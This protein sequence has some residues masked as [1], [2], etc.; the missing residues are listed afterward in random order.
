[1]TRTALDHDHDHEHD[2]DDELTLAVAAAERRAALTGPGVDLAAVRRRGRRR[3]TARRVA[4]V[5]PVLAVVAVAGLAWQG[6]GGG[7]ASLA[8]AGDGAVRVTPEPISEPTRKPAQKPTQPPV[9]PERQRA[10]L[11]AFNAALAAA[12]PG[13]VPLTTVDGSWWH[14]EQRYT[15]WSRWEVDGRS[16][17]GSE[18]NLSVSESEDAMPV[19]TSCPSEPGA[20]CTAQD[21]PGGVHVVTGTTQLSI[22]GE[23]DEVLGSDQVPFATAVHPDGRVVTA[24][25]HLSVRD[26]SDVPADGSLLPPHWTVEELRALVLHPALADVPLP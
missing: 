15:G 22:G 16:D 26:R 24:S 6:A 18:L 21:L 7:A 12:D 14:N 5:A 8:P 9:D 3:R 20:A 10:A 2:E 25:A 19:T 23:G 4:A 13:F 17:P 11:A 1:M